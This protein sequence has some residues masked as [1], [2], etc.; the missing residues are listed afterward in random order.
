MASMTAGRPTP[1]LAPRAVAKPTVKRF[2]AEAE[3]MRLAR[4][5]AGEDPLPGL[6]VRQRQT[7]SEVCFRQ[8]L[9]LVA[10]RSFCAS[11]SHP[12]APKPCSLE[13]LLQS[14]TTEEALFLLSL[15]TDALSYRL[16]EPIAHGLLQAAFSLRLV[17]WPEDDAELLQS[18]PGGIG[19]ARPGGSLMAGRLAAIIASELRAEAAAD[20]REEWAAAEKLS[21]ATV[22]SPAASEEL[23]PSACS[24]L[25]PTHPRPSTPMS[26]P[27][28]HLPCPVG[29]CGPA[30]HRRCLRCACDVAAFGPMPLCRSCFHHSTRLLASGVEACRR[31]LS[32]WHLLEADGTHAPDGSRFDFLNE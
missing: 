21:V 12:A 30:P 6:D 24:P 4:W 32:K 11:C 9:G 23:P 31:D 10:L 20:R 19:D 1:P 26:I 25:L 28:P 17:R 29:H 7:R 27:R 22:I 3:A 2:L 5:E 16:P 14:A 13:G 8:Q 15:C 18:P